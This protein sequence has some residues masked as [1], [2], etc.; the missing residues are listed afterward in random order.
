M[1]WPHKRWTIWTVMSLVCAIAA[2]CAIR[3]N[4]QNQMWKRESR[5]IELKLQYEITN[6]TISTAM[7][8]LVH[9]GRS[10]NSEGTKWGTGDWDISM[11][12]LK[13]G[14][15]SG[16]IRLRVWAKGDSLALKPIHV[17]ILDQ[18]LSEAPWIASLLRTYRE[19]GWP[20]KVTRAPL[21]P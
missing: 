5:R 15:I 14:A 19:R 8:D 20:C 7:S 16:P 10:M 1:R 18:D 4:L 9:S 3:V 6:E 13:E 12:D 21:I 11:R 17:E 2:V